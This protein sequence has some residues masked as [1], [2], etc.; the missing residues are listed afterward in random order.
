MFTGLAP[1]G[2]PSI[3]PAFDSGLFLHYPF[4]RMVLDSAG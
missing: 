4:H 3:R 2:T 1:H